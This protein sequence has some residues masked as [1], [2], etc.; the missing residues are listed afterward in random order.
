MSDGLD[1]NILT[2]RAKEIAAEVEIRMLK[3]VSYQ[4]R[5]SVYFLQSAKRMELKLQKNHGT[6]N[7]LSYCQKIGI[8]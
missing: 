2:G 6:Q 5:K 1:I 3:M 4:R 7:V 8:I